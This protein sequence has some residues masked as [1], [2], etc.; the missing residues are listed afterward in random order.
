MVHHRTIG[1]PQWC[2]A[3]LGLLMLLCQPKASCGQAIRGS[4]RDTTTNSPV[5]DAQLAMVAESG[6]TVA[7]VVSDEHG[8]FQAVAPHWGSFVVSIRRLGYGPVIR[9]PATLHPGDTLEIT[10]YLHPLALPLDPVVVEAE[11]AVRFAQVRYLQAEG[12]YRRERVTGGRHLAPAMIEKRRNSARYI[13]DYL[14]ALPGVRVNQG[15][16]AGA[17]RDLK[18]RCG[19]PAF[20]IDGIRHRGGQIELA[21]D[22][23]DVLAIEVYD[24]PAQ[25]P[26]QY[27]GA[28]AVVLWSRHR[29]EARMRP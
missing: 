24:G 19:S 5:P 18:L 23:Y 6:D 12:F 9:A 28:C 7:V 17:R 3:V 26:E 15:F 10:Y 13:D 4:I 25:A 21:I 20:F 14:T 27:G 29:A 22:P 11:A 2:P 16:L 8:R 1:F